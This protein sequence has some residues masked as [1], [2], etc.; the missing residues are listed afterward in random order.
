MARW[1]RMAFGEGW[2]AGVIYG[3]ERNS[4]GKVL[5]RSSNTLK[6]AWDKGFRD[7]FRKKCW[8]AVPTPSNPHGT[9]VLRFF[10]GG[11]GM[12]DHFFFSSYSLFSQKRPFMF[13]NTPTTAQKWPQTRM[14]QRFPLLERASNIFPTPPTLPTPPG[15]VAVLR[16]GGIDS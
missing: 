1:K 10:W 13:S 9:R 7:F 4:V 2:R 12:L 16:T 3:I 8:N 5:E 6:P 11:V 15:I 14:A